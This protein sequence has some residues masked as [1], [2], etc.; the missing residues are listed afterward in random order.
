MRVLSIVILALSL[1]AC[2]AVPIK[3][4]R[5]GVAACYYTVRAAFA[6]AADMRARG[7]LSDEQRAK[8]LQIGDEALATCDTARVAVGAGDLTKA[9]NQLKAAELI[10]LRL[11]A[12]TKEAK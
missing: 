1:S 12:A 11:E 9:E 10:L 6:T 7:Q 3:T 8:V 2:P 5:E 4:P